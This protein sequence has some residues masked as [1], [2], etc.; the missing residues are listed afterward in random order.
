VQKTPD[1]YDSPWKDAL[2]EFFS[3]FMKFFFPSAYEQIDWRE[4]PHFEEKDLRKLWRESEVPKRYVD[5]LV[6]VALHNGER[7]RVFIHV[8]VQSDWEGNFAR[9]MFSYHYRLFDLHKAPLASLVVLADQSPNWRPDKYEYEVLG[10]RLKLDYPTVSASCRT[11]SRT[12]WPRPASSKS[13][14]GPRKSWTPGRWKMS[15]RSRP[16]VVRRTRR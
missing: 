2:R 8:E 16:A 4:E 14:N 3:E 12:G 9:R 15:S 10:C 13:N 7:E 6:K 1:D 5:K 11:G